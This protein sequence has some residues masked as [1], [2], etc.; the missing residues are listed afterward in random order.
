P[1]SPSIHFEFGENASA[2]CAA[3]P[4]PS[5][6]RA[7]RQPTVLAAGLVFLFLYISSVLVVVV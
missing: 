6:P 3:L 4:K 1:Q 7:N 2:A 5:A